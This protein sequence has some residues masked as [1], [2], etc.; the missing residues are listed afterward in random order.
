MPTYHPNKSQLVETV[1]ALSAVSGLM[2]AVSAQV[3]VNEFL[4]RDSDA[5]LEFVEIFNRSEEDVDLSRISIS[6]GRKVP[7]RVTASPHPF[8]PG[9]YVVLVRDSLAF[10]AR[11][12]GPRIEVPSWPALNNGGDAI[13]VWITGAAV[14]SVLFDGDW[15]AYGQSLERVDPNAPAISP[16]NWRASADPSG[17]TP[18]SENSVYRPDRTAPTLVEAEEWV[19]G[20]VI[21]YASE[22]LDPASLPSALIRF[23][24]GDRPLSARLSSDHR[25]IVIE[26]WSGAD[27]TALTVEGL[28][29][30]SGNVAGRESIAV[31]R[32][33][34]ASDVIIN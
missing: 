4:F 30:A 32:Q 6:D 22:P 29:D 31:A 10:S 8:H 28:A 7:V 27:L 21:V 13:F 25:K 33:P 15:G 26:P 14:D 23:G 17:G 2:Q 11:F 20:Y 5:Q 12:N 19:D 16:S 1:L 18:G 24:S 9:E 34:R 3:I